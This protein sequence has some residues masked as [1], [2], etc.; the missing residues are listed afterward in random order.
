LAEQS[1]AASL[2]LI[3]SELT[4]PERVVRSEALDAVIQFASSNA[5]PRI[6]E[7]AATVEDPREKVELIEAADFL[8]RPSLT[9]LRPMLQRRKAERPPSRTPVVPPA[10]P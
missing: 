5:V 7:I 9:E 6:R 4:N 2:E 10:E 8:A 1:D 3:L